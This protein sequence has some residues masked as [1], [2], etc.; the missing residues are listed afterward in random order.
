MTFIA[1]HYSKAKDQ[2]PIGFFKKD[3]YLV[4]TPWWLKKIFPGCLWDI[5]SGKKTLYLSFDDGPHP[6]ITPYVLQLL[7]QYN[8]KA[9]F[10]CIG[11]NVQK[12]PEI[13]QQL[14]NEGHVTGNHT[15]NHLNGW[16]TDDRT[17]VQNIYEAEKFI[18]SDLFRPPY[19]RIT[20]SQIKLLKKERPAMKIAMW[21][22]LAGD[23]VPELKPELCFE[24]IKRKISKDDII[25]FHDTDKAFERLEYTLPKTLQYFTEMGFSFEKFP[26]NPE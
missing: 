25:V 1:P 5:K 22:I 8:A 13:Y 19:G 3:H 26:S 18:S 7:K 14:I 2:S 23:W 15:Q 12:Y 16:K 11:E 10:F 9:T 17:Y 6:T 24:R 20:K 21:N 4:K